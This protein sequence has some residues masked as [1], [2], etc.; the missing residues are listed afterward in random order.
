MA[1]RVLSVLLPISGYDL[2]NK[3]FYEFLQVHWGVAMQTPKCKNNNIENY[4]KFCRKPEEGPQNRCSMR[5]SVCVECHMRLLSSALLNV[6]CGR[7]VHW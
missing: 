6:L 2:A 4:L 3:S 7:K 5:S 1:H